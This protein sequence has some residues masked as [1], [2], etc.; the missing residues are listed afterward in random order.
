MKSEGTTWSESGWPGASET[1]PPYFSAMP[2]QTLQGSVKFGP[3]A[4]L[5]VP[6]RDEKDERRRILGAVE[7]LESY[8]ATLGA[9]PG[10]LQF[11]WRA[12]ADESNSPD[13]P[14]GVVTISLQKSTREARRNALL[15]L[16]D[17]LSE[18]DDPVVRARVS[19]RVR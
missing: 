14:T 3:L 10:S 19:I 8:A 12:Y 7:Q 5:V 9:E 1:T 17:R 13:R 16:L 4:E 15:A 6:L 11:E 2:A 18:H